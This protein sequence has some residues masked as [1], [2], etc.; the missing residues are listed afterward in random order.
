MGERRPPPPKDTIAPETP[1]IPEARD[2]MQTL[3]DDEVLEAA[4]LASMARSSAPPPLVRDDSDVEIEIVSERFASMRPFETTQLAKEKEDR[5]LVAL[6]LSR[7]GGETRVPVR[8]VSH[9]K[10]AGAGLD[11]NAS[12]VALHVD[13]ES[14]IARIIERCGLPVAEALRALVTLQERKLIAI[15]P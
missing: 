8:V 1:R 5:A 9:E 4:R 10:L 7:L 13:G 14:T 3:T 12:A 15:R 2:A 11:P 6:H